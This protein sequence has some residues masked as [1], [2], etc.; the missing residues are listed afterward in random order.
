MAMV[1]SLVGT[2]GWQCRF[3]RRVSTLRL[4]ICGECDRNRNMEA[5]LGA[6]DSQDGSLD[7]IIDW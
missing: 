2:S 3:A 4:P 1:G 5:D 7:G 6:L